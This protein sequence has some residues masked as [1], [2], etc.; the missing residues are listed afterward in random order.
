MGEVDQRD[1]VLEIGGLIFLRAT[2]DKLVESIVQLIKKEGKITVAQ[3]RDVTGSS[4]KVIL[5]V[6]EEMDRRQITRRSGD[7]RELAG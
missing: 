4:R 6:L 7:Y 1:E 5:P 3:A 2:F